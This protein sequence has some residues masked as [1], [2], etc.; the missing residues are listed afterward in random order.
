MLKRDIEKKNYKKFGFINGDSVFDPVLDPVFYQQLVEF[1]EFENL[2]DYAAQVHQAYY[3]C[4]VHSAQDFCKY[5]TSSEFHSY[6][7]QLQRLS[8]KKHP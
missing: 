7:S 5:F 2:Y 1:F 4:R 8:I 6:L 3:N